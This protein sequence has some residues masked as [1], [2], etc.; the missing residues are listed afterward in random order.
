[1]SKK[2]IRFRSNILAYFKILWYH[3]M[4]G[5]PQFICLKKN[6]T[7]FILG[8]KL[9]QT[10]YF[11]FTCSSVE[12]KLRQ[13]L[14]HKLHI[15]NP[16][17][18][19]Q[20]IDEE[21]NILK[22][23]DCQKWGNKFYIISVLP[24]ENGSSLQLL[25][26]KIFMNLKNY[27]VHHFP[28]NTKITILSYFPIFPLSIEHSPYSWNSPIFLSSI[29]HHIFNLNQNLS[30]STSP[31]QFK[32]L[33]LGAKRIWNVFTG[34]KIK[35]SRFN[36]F[37]N[38]FHNF[39]NQTQTTKSLFLLI[40]QSKNVSNHFQIP[41]ERTSRKRVNQNMSKNGKIVNKHHMQQN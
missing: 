30:I 20:S 15:W 22:H 36:W 1:M 12:V 34:N 26:K 11:A 24:F 8:T 7:F 6:D 31:P 14:S 41:T 40:L 9:K 19:P 25:Y 17:F 13:E 32:C 23:D 35:E 4:I 18:W 29:F 5:Q 10:S 2:T 28:L 37:L 27:F 21:I 16:T 33:P 38:K 39:L 3:H